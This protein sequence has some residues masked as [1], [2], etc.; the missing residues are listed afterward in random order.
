MAEFI[1]HAKDNKGIDKTG[2]IQ[3]PDQKAAAQVLRKR[4]LVVISIKA[5]SA[6]A[7]GFLNRFLNRVS[8]TD[9]VIMTRQLATMVSS[10]LV[11]SESIDILIDQ[12]TNKTLKKALSEISA[13]IKGG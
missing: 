8:F 1:Y 6:P 12:Q 4:G 5:K 11:L 10:G 13:D 2:E 3:V 9:T 7:I